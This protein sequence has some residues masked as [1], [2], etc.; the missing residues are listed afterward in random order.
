MTK[1]PAQPCQSVLGNWFCQRPT[2]H[3]GR[4]EMKL[5]GGHVRWRVRDLETERCRELLDRTKRLL[6]GNTGDAS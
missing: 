6:D 3:R 1:R 5:A 2:G 4:H